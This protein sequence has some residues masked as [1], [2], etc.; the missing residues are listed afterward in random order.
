MRTKT[1]P[2][3]DGFAKVSVFIFLA[4]QLPTSDV[5]D[6]TPDKKAERTK[7]VL[8]HPDVGDVSVDTHRVDA[9]G[10]CFS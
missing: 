8:K 10:N 1:K 7:L 4:V 5:E 6:V 9:P 2:L 3:K